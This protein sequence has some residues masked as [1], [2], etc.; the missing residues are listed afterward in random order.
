M[1]HGPVASRILRPGWAQPSHS[2]AGSQGASGLYRKAHA[3][4]PGWAGPR[5]QVRTKRTAGG[6]SRRALRSMRRARSDSGPVAVALA[7]LDVE[8]FLF[9]VRGTDALL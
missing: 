9:T 3:R 6:F 1:R 7:L 4:S 8:A 5:R 2:G